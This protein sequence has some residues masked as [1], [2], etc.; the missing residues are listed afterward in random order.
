[1]IS[2][3]QET[4]ATTLPLSSIEIDGERERRSDWAQNRA[5]C[6][7]NIKRYGHNDAQMNGRQIF[8]HR[9]EG[10]KAAMLAAYAT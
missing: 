8:G 4:R 2:T 5:G 6:K 3:V 10:Y 7:R 1:M 9:T